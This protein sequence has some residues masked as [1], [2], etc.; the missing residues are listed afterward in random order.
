MNKIISKIQ[1]L[2]ALSESPNQ[3]E[4]E[5][6]A[7]KAQELLIKHNL[8]MEQVEN[9]D[10]GMDEKE[11]L[12]MG[13]IPLWISSLLTGIAD[14]Y[15]CT[16]ISTFGWRKHSVTL[17]GRN[18]NVKVTYSMFVYLKNVIYSLGKEEKEKYFRSGYGIRYM[19]QFRLG[20]AF[21]VSQRLDE[22]LNSENVSNEKAL[23]VM[24]YETTKKENNE[25]VKKKYGELGT[26]KY[27]GCHVDEVAFNRGV[28]KSETIGLDNQLEN[29]GKIQQEL[30]EEA[31]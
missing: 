11:V 16:S 7:I 31:I 20:L 3:K 26:R 22:I 30:F 5:S 27:Q 8:S 14:A 29:K 23:V 13:R 6:A 24:L 2:L 19:N 12:S 1:K 15:M 18:A 10:L 28:T 4:A 17:I 9:I 25:Y 21:G